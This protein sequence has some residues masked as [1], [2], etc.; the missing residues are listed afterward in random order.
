MLLNTSNEWTEAWFCPTLS[1]P[2]FF[3]VGSPTDSRITGKINHNVIELFPCSIDVN[4][5]HIDFSSSELQLILQER[6]TRTYEAVFPCIGVERKYIGF[7][8]T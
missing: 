6:W 5:N 3:K 7:N 1:Q 4:K 8:Q 2:I